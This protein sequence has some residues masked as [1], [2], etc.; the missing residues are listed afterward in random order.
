MI[1]FPCF[2]TFFAI[3]YRLCIILFKCNNNFTYLEYYFC[4]EIEL[5]RLSIS[6]TK[7][8]LFINTI[9]KDSKKS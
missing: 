7:F 5:C 1:E 6:D 9:L 8:L 3:G 4:T 2:Y